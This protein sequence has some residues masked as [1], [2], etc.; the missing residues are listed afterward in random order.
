MKGRKKERCPTGQLQGQWYQA[1]LP[2]LI[3]W[4][5][6]VTCLMGLI[7]SSPTML[8]MPELGFRIVEATKT[9][10]GFRTLLISATCSSDQ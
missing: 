2:V 10:P 8:P 9:P 6:C 1:I 3:E 5:T 4:R 7:A